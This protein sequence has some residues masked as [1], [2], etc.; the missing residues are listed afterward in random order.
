M[1][2][3]GAALPNVVAGAIVVLA[4]YNVAF[5]SLGIVAAVGMTLYWVAMPETGPGTPNPALPRTGEA[6]SQQMLLA[7]IFRFLELHGQKK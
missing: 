6:R 3:I 2:G 4:G 7:R 1:W 5:L